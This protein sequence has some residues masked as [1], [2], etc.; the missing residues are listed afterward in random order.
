MPL[1]GE[2]R[3][4]LTWS[5]EGIANTLSPETFLAKMKRKHGPSF[6][7]SAYECEQ[8][9]EIAERAVA[10]AKRLGVFY[11]KMTAVMDVT[12]CHVNGY[13]L[14]L[15]KLMAAPDGD[16]GHDVFGIRRHIDR[17]DGTIEGCFVPRCALGMSFKA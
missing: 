16:F 7:C 5:V 14:D 8:I 4:D 2:E 11:P 10:M 12:A 9:N 1:K 15:A 6:D 13:A 17:K 3:S